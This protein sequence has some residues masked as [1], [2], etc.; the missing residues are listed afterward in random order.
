MSRT[1]PSSDAARRALGTRQGTANTWTLLLSDLTSIRTQDLPTESLPELLVAR[2]AE[3][4]SAFAVVSPQ[5]TFTFGEV[6]RR[7]ELLGKSLLEPSP[8]RSRQGSWQGSRHGS[9]QGREL[10]NC[11]APLV[12]EASECEEHPRNPFV[13]LMV[14]PGPWMVAGPLGAWMAGRGYFALDASHPTERIQQMAQDAEGS[15]I[16]EAVQQL[17]C[18]H[19]WME[20]IW[21]EDILFHALHALMEP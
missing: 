7:A 13:G 6:L 5:G 15:D 11:R 14:G 8:D 12:E 16:S 9:W 2:A 1:W 4:P 19:A 17:K 10:L 20:A 21:M 18:T 3:N